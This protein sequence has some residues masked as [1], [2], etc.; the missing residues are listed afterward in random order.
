MHLITLIGVVDFF[1]MSFKLG[2]IITVM[3][4]G[5]HISYRILNCADLGIEGIFPLGGCVCVLLMHFGVPAIIATIAG[6]IVGGIGGLI[7]ALL[8]TKLKIPMILSGIITL[9]GFYSINL[10]ILGISNSGSNTAI[11]RASLA[12]EP[13]T[14]IFY[15]LVPLFNS[16][17]MKQLYSLTLS[18]IIIMSVILALVVFAIYFFFGTEIGMSI[19]ATGDNQ[20]MAKA[21]GINTDRMII[22]GLIIS[23]ALIGL[24]G[25]LFAQNIGLVSVSNGKGMIVVGLA[26]III[27]EV[28]FGRRSYKLQLI[29]IIVGTIIYYLMRQL[30]IVL[31]LAEF[32]DLASAIIIVIILSVP[33]IKN[34]F[35][36]NHKV[37]GGEK[38]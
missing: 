32:L 8:H 33:L 34:K 7:T 22:I 10:A 15:K 9:T 19:R 2:L 30:S 31:N 17:G 12:I 29:S 5:V 23:N 26:A 21:Q 37:R 16:L 20:Q 13:G 1:S 14:S 25:A 3:V 35:Q 27:A 6:L 28:I 4:I 11:T 38:C 18:T 24:A 36:K